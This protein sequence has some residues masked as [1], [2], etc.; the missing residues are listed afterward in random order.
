MPSA[1]KPGPHR[2]FV[3]VLIWAL[4]SAGIG[5]ALRYGQQGTRS[6]RPDPASV[7]QVLPSPK[8]QLPP[9]WPDL[10]HHPGKSLGQLVLQMAVILMATGIV[11]A[12]FRKLGQPA[13]VGEILAGILLGPSLLGWLW[14]GGSSFIFSGPS[15]QLLRL[16]SQVGVAIYMFAIGMEIEP[17][18]FRGGARPALL[19]SQASIAVPFMFGVIVALGLYVPYA[20]AGASFLA[21]AL[22]LGIAFSMTAFPVMARI[23]EE[24]GIS[25]TTVGLNALAA[26]AIG[27]A[28][29]WAI[30]ALVVALA[31]SQPMAT[32]LVE[33]GLIVALVA[34]MLVTVRPR[35][36]VWL[37]VRY[38][39]AERAP[40]K[41]AIRV[42]IFFAASAMATQLLGIHALFGAFL[43]G[44]ILP[45][46]KA[47]LHLGKRVERVSRTILLP[48]FF[49]FSGLRTYVGALDGLQ[50][51]LVCI[52]ILIVSTL[53]KI[54]STMATA[55][56]E[57][58][59]WR[60]SMSF[61]ALMNSRG[62][63]ELI[64]LNVGYDLGIVSPSLFVMLVLMGLI[65]TFL[66]GPLLDLI[67]SRGEPAVPPIS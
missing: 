52:G 2:Y 10:M 49:A 23:I 65:A 7:I 54:G 38:L 41:V 5:V 30:L 14:P 32:T 63:M 64:A 61:G 11:G 24:R 26:A 53:A 16:L 28:S 3:H 15:V 40:P 43:A 47:L 17:E 34:F 8:A 58:M 27:D 1:S 51:W 9:A 29:A 48:L 25:K 56:L 59:G 19:I 57:G 18:S 55:R 62:L 66:T 21:F 45:R 36:P 67:E 4:C 37:K 33:L 42:V 22:F 31:R 35:L 39:P 12:L 44:A 13:V 50:P 60:E 20:G 46:H 6:S